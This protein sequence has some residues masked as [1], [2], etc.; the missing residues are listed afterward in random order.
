M[1]FKDSSAEKF[2]FSPYDWVLKYKAGFRSGLLFGNQIVH[3][4][5]Q[6]GNLLHRF[7]DLVFS[8]SS[9]IEWKAFSR[10]QFCKWFETEWQKLLPAEGAN[11][12]LPGN[13]ALA[14]S[15]QEEGKLAIWSLIEHMRAASVTKTAVNFS[16][17][18]G[19]RLDRIQRRRSGG[20]CQLSTEFDASDRTLAC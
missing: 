18:A 6:R 10:E 2:I 15:L 11:L 19:A 7:S 1:L 9:L 20:G 5:R 3:A 12:L 16:P 14:E 17:A 8:P 4:S 13:R